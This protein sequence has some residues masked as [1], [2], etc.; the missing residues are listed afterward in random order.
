M[1]LL[2][3]KVDRKIVRLH[4]D[5][6]WPKGKNT[7]THPGEHES[8]GSA[9]E[10]A[11]ASTDEDEA[12]PW[13][14]SHGYAYAAGWGSTNQPISDFVSPSTLQFT[15][16]QVHEPSKCQAWYDTPTGTTC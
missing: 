4:S 7:Q 15:S 5:R 8:D 13:G 2:L 3:C 11:E 6:K 16:V 12:F 10:K 1:S 14:I 9:E